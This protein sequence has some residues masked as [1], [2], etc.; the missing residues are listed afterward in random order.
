MTSRV[1]REGAAV[2][3]CTRTGEELNSNLG[4][5]I[6]RAANHW[7]STP[8]VWLQSKVRSSRI[9]GLQNGTGTLRLRI[10]R[11]P[12]PVLVAGTAPRSLWFMELAS[13]S[14]EATE[15]IPGISWNTEIHYPVH[16][17]GVRPESDKFSA[18]TSYSSYQF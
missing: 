7:L 13:A 2:P 16:A 15:E 10:L 18:T 1:E 3:V 12:L 9:C 11:F 6:P 8:A 4:P 5:A 17:T 14:Q